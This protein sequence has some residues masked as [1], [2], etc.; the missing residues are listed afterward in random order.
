MS[1]LMAVWLMAICMVSF[2]SIISNAKDGE[3]DVMLKYY[4]GITVN[5]GDN[6]WSIADQYIDYT[7]YKDKIAYINEVYSINNLENES[8]I[9]AGQRLIVPYYSEK[10]VK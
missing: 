10:F 7:Q 3:G 1:L 2:H 4:T 9:C 6:L 5:A 8:E